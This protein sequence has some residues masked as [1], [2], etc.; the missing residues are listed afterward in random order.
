[1]K[2]NWFKNLKLN[3]KISLAVGL[4]FILVM[5]FVIAV[6]YQ[7][8]SDTVS[9]Q[10]EEQVRIIQENRKKELKN[11][12]HD[13]EKRT[14]ALAGDQKTID[15]IRFYNT[16]GLEMTMNNYGYT[17]LENARRLRQYLA[18]I[19]AGEVAYITNSAGIVLGDSRLEKEGQLPEL[20]GSELEESHFSQVEQGDIVQV[21]EMSVLLFSRPIY[22]EARNHTSSAQ[23]G[24]EGTGGDSS[25]ASEKQGPE[26]IGYLVT[27]VN[28][29]L[30]SATL[31]S[32]LG[33]RGKIILL[34]RDGYILNHPEQDRVGTMLQ[35]KWFSQQLA[36]G[37]ERNKARQGGYLKI[38]EEA[39]DGFYLAFT[40]PDEMIYG[41]AV[42]LRDK[43]IIIAAFGLLL[44]FVVTFYVMR[45]MLNPLQQFVA[46]FRKLQAGSLK[47]KVEI[48]SNDEFGQLSRNF[49]LMTENLL[50]IAVK[51]NRA[52]EET[53]ITSR[54]LA[55]ASSDSVDT[56]SEVANST[57]EFTRMSEQLSAGSQQM[58]GTAEEVNKLA[59][60]GIRYMEDT[61]EEMQ[62]IIDSSERAGEAFAGLKKS[63]GEIENIVSVIS[64]IAEQTNLLALNA[65]IEAARAGSNGRG[66]AVVA[67]EVRELAEETQNSA[68]SIKDLI[69]SLVER[70][71]VA[72]EVNEQNNAQIEEGA[73][74]LNQTA[75]V[76]SKIADRIKELVTQI[77]E[78][79]SAGQ[80]LSAGS[81][82]VS[83]ATEE[84]TAM[85]EEISASA[86][87]LS[88]MAEELK[89]LVA[90]FKV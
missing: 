80:E 11:I 75:E 46:A 44:I 67:D 84:Q 64:G 48:D 12:L 1:M 9:G 65:A 25:S 17:I 49:N 76:F 79:A 70:A 71:R 63:A 33:D 39:G 55:G 7:F 15:Y 51:V 73:R 52:A 30:F 31:N 47:E 41:P 66:F 83:A 32:S 6:S 88:S 87:Q 62:E 22:E 82:E 21:G 86:Q 42:D 77:E 16:F 2:F 50:D 85:M 61:R 54:Q 18:G 13:L 74:V 3:W 45:R 5:V 19:D 29:E 40:V 60:D 24:E 90:R 26:P 28:L 68:S 69:Q 59:R 89:G 4:L 34:N 23:A 14:K 8:T 10:I 53:L 57:R 78:V 27:A 72:V 81:E 43:I 36:S 37:I 58:A 56:V 20:I 35:D 38:I